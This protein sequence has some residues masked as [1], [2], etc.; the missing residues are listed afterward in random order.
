LIPD[1]QFR[2]RDEQFA[3]QKCHDNTTRYTI[4]DFS[5]NEEDNS[6]TCPNGKKLVY[7]GK[8]TLRNNQIDKWVASCADCKVCPF[9]DKCM[10]LKGTNKSPR[11]T[12][13][14]TDYGGKENLSEKMREKIDNPIY[15]TLY[16]ERMRIIEPCFSDICCCKGMDHFTMRGKTKTDGQWLLYA[17]VHNIA[18]C[19]GAL[20]VKHRG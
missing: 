5:Y 6:Y 19:A 13:A 2:K 1:Q 4:K 7:K 10:K 14:V 20:G 3:D 16:G 9:K 17:I 18:K 12:L 8:Y 15:R 11:R